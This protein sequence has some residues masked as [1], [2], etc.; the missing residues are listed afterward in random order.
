V[1]R[2][3]A[4]LDVHLG[5]FG[6]T[7]TQGVVP[8]ELRR[9]RGTAQVITCATVAARVRLVGIAETGE[10]SYLTDKAVDVAEFACWPAG[11]GFGFAVI[12]RTATNPGELYVGHDGCL[13]RIT[14][15]NAFIERAN[16]VAQVIDGYAPSK[17]APA[18]KQHYF[19]FHSP[20][21]AASRVPLVIVIHGGPHAAATSS[22]SYLADRLVDAGF[23]VAFANL[24]GSI[25]WGQG[26]ASC[27]LGAVGSKDM[28]DL[29]LLLA[30][31]TSRYPWIDAENVF[32]TGGS[33]GGF[34]T[35]L[36]ICRS[37]RF[38]AAVSERSISNWVSFA[39]T[40]DIGERYVASQ[41][42]LAENAAILRDAS[43]VHL[44]ENVTT[45]ILILHGDADRRCPLPQA[46]EFHATLQD[47]GKAVEIEVFKGV[48]H[49]YVHS[50]SLPLQVERMDRIV[51]WLTRHLREP[52]TRD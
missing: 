52:E 21:P 49:D 30:D 15:G 16:P 9:P 42:G 27:A 45:P 39:S 48:G 40:S 34:V 17:W 22:Y 19:L 50:L 20:P 51:A 33:Y 31:L 5:N 13:D 41:L 6:L 36:A 11:Q 43:P 29:W 28:D 10:L 35:N 47:L 8:A 2:R 26:Y 18:G 4:E 37:S 1:A 23:C 3:S 38:R 25:G 32:L 14:Y 44:A 24:I 7:D 12:G 46:T